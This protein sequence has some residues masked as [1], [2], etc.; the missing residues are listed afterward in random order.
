MAVGCGSGETVQPDNGALD[1]REEKLMPYPPASSRVVAGPPP[2][3]RRQY[4][5]AFRGPGVLPAASEVAGKVHQRSQAPEEQVPFFGRQQRDPHVQAILI[6]RQ[7]SQQEPGHEPV[8]GVSHR[9]RHLEVAVVLLLLGLG[10][11]ARW[12]ERVRR[13]AFL[14][15]RGDGRGALRGRLM[16][17]QPCPE[18]CA[19]GGILEHHGIVSRVKEGSRRDT[20]L[21]SPAG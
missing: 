19:R 9:T 8:R 20:T 7:V 10:L 14:T 15:W 17:R 2:G 11:A 21:I 16:G 6:R 1:K 4:R 12:P 3:R 18:G 5:R 13:R